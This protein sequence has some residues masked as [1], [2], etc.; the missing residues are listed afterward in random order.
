MPVD[1]VQGAIAI[2]GVGNEL[3][4]AFKDVGGHNVQRFGGLMRGGS[5]R[6]DVKEVRQQRFRADLLSC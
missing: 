4:V 5:E 2:K 1:G 6:I 3:I